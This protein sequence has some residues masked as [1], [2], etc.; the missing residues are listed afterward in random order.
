ML[1]IV[2]SVT[3]RFSVGSDDERSEPARN[4]V[5]SNNERIVTVRNPVGSDDVY[6]WVWLF[7][8]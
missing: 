2:E 7:F 3:D 1:V 5:G 8:S 6:V 4:S